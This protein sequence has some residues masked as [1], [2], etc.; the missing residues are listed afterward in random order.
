VSEAYD[1]AAFVVVS[2]LCLIAAATLA[3]ASWPSGFRRIV[4]VAVFARILGSMAR[5][6]VVT[7][8]YGRGDAL[9]YFDTGWWM[10]DALRSGDLEPLM[11]VPKAWGTPFL[12]R[13][14]ALVLFLVGPSLRAEFVVFSMFPLIG[15]CLIAVSFAR[16]MPGADMRRV[17]VLLLL[18]PSLV[19]WPSSVGKESLI[20]LAVGLTV[21][22]YASV[23][24]VRLLAI[25]GGLL[26]AMGIRPHI[27]MML[28]VCVAA[29]EWLKPV[30][31]MS[32]QQILRGVVLAAL[33]AFT[34]VSGLEQFGLD[35]AASVEAFI[36]TK[37]AATQ[38][39][40]SR[41]SVV[42]GPAAL[43]MAFVNVL[44][45]PF[46]WEVRNPLIAISVLEIFLF[47]GLVGSAGLP[48]AFFRAW[49]R[50]QALRYL[51]PVTVVLIVFYGAFVSNLGILAR[52]RVVVLPFLFLIAEGARV[53]EKSTKASRRLPPAPV[54][55]SVPA[56][57]VRA[58]V[59]VR[60][61]H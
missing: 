36:D 11:S 51:V 31:S 30:R 13:V 34:V 9:R 49:R 28:A 24:V 16:M 46:P 40:G 35:D 12:E 45:R 42:S 14:S 7:D 18:W 55:S 25:S 57:A 20:L 4:V 22:G 54:R 21:F 48:R 52:Q 38:T 5:L 29:A 10:A 8:Y 56:R 26:L 2:G 61:P 43:P 44:M 58:V 15:L 47:W 33:A 59:P 37:A 53:L 39:G 60:P 17:S 6:W 41:I 23:G 1:I 27:A 50:S 32:W 3:P 19:F